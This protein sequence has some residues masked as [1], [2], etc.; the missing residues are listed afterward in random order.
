MLAE[1]FSMYVSSNQKDWDTYIPLVLFGY[2]VSPNPTTGESPFY[3]LYGR[4]PG[5]PLDVNFTPPQDLSKSAVEHRQ[6]I[7]TNLQHAYRIV[8]ENTQLAQQKMKDYYD[9]NA[10]APNY[11]LGDKVWVNTPKT[12]K[13]LSKKL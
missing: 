1:S 11:Q 8:R 9:L 3:L 6:R 10:K 12:K 2:R 13:G 7:I 5:L 4:E